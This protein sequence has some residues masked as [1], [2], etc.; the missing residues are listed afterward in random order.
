MSG[1]VGVG[2]YDAYMGRMW[3][4]EQRKRQAAFERRRYPTDL[5]DEEWEQIT[6]L[7]P[8]PAKHGR[9]RSVD[10]REIRNAIRY[11]ARGLQ[12]ADAAN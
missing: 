3:T 2:S 9:K 10:L 11:L 4:K 8:K 5:T 1:R 7:L 12:L 6:P